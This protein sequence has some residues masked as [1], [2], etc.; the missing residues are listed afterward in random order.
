MEYALTEGDYRVTLRHEALAG[1]PRWVFHV[2]SKDSSKDG[3]EGWDSVAAWPTHL[4]DDLSHEDATRVVRRI[5]NTRLPMAEF[6]DGNEL[7]RYA[8]HVA[9]T[10]HLAPLHWMSSS[11]KRR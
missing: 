8:R 6:A 3:I 4:A 9:E 2:D 5:A 7:E 10:V 1:E 11:S